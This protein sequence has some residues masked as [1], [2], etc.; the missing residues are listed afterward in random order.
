MEE[1]EYKPYIS[2]DKE[3]PEFTWKSIV[4]GTGLGIVFAWANA[5][6]GLISGLTISASIPV[7]VMSVAIFAFLHKAFKARKGSP[8]ETNMSQTIGSA[9]ESLAA[10]VIFTI[11]ASRP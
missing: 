8:L 1:Q 10:G 5:Y 2:H 11:P 4:I 7:S 9:G 6:V 3:P